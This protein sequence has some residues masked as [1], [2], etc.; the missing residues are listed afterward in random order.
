[1]TRHTLFAV[2]LYA[3]DELTGADIR[4]TICHVAGLDAAAMD[5]ALAWAAEYAAR[6]ITGTAPE[7]DCPKSVTG[8]VRSRLGFYVEGAVMCGDARVSDIAAHVG[9]LLIA[10]YSDEF[11]AKAAA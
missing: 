3:R 7:D 2:T 8:L 6:R 11:A 9:D 4:D 10:Q 5:D 1:M